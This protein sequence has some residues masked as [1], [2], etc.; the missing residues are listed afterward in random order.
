MMRF[1]IIASFGAVL[2]FLSSPALGGEEHDR[3]IRAG[4]FG[5]GQLAAIASS[6]PFDLPPVDPG[7]PLG[8]HGWSEGEPGFAEVDPAELPPDVSVLGAGANIAVQ[9]VALDPALAILDPGAGLTPLAPGQ[10]FVLGGPGF[11]THPV[12]LI[13]SDSPGFNPAQTLWTGTF[14]LVDLG[15]TNYAASANFDLTFRPTP[16]P[17]TAAILA[18]GL[19]A[20]L[21]RR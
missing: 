7:N 5:S 21:R 9:V 3:D 12:W 13:D 20:A 14:R 2:A 18:V 19:L 6:D 16:E 4:V 1:A 15:S 8:L 17:A 10:N 11:D